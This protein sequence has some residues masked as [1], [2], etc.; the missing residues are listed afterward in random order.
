MMLP[1]RQTIPGSSR[2]F[3]GL[4]LLAA[5]LTFPD[6]E[7]QARDECG[8]LAS[9]AATCADMAYASGI[10]YDVADGWGNGIAG[11]IALTVTG[12][13]STAIT[14]ATATGWG[15][16]IVLRTAEHA[17][18]TRTIALTVGTGTNAVTIAQSSASITGGFDDTGVVL[19]QRGTGASPTTVTLGSGVAIGTMTAPM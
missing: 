5:A 10:R 13:S 11:D 7:A 14:S 4:V 19:H 17:T 9:G 16:G 3:C 12:G 18:D 8:A 2:G 15:S 1:K 6:G